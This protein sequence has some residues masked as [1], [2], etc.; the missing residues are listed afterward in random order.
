MKKKVFLLT[1]LMV[2]LLAFAACGGNGSTPA[3]D[4]GEPGDNVELGEPVSGGILHEF[5][6]LGFSIEFPASWE[7]KYGVTESG[8]GDVQ[9]VQIYH[10]A[11][12]DELFDLLGYDTGGGLVN[13]GRAEGE[14]YTYDDPPIMAGGSIFMAQ[15][16]GYTYFANFPSG[17]E[18]NY[19]DPDSAAT[20]EYVEMAGDFDPIHWDFLVNSFKLL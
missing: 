1:A 4:A 2:L 17:V 9:V 5:D 8:S 18:H 19:E 11:T 12:R 7:G 13:L 10:I 3:N 16:G 14:H 15:T 20:I 6:T